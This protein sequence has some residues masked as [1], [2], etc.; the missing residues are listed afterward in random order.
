ML[1][2]KQTAA[3][4]GVVLMVALGSAAFILSEAPGADKGIGGASEI[5]GQTPNPP[6][7]MMKPVGKAE[8]DR[9][10]G[11]NQQAADEK[12]EAEAAASGVSA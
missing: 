6:N 8:A 10:A 1:D 12:A 3:L 9:R 7:N 4:G 2:T 11:V 5:R